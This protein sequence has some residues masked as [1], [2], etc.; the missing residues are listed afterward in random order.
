M[1]V[2]SHPADMLNPYQL[3]ELA[4]CASPDTLTSPGAMFLLHVQDATADHVSHGGDADDLSEIADNAPN[5]YTWKR[6]QEFTDLAAWQEDAT[7]LG[8]STDDMTA[9]AGVCLY[10]IAE[11]L[12]RALIEQWQGDDDDE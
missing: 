2:P 7:E 1:T 9:A 5:V 12:A 10:L 6:W 8:A 4:D 11:R 3:A